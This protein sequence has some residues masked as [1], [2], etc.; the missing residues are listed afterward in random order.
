MFNSSN[1]IL[2]KVKKHLYRVPKYSF[3]T[4]V[5]VV[6]KKALKILKSYFFRC[7]DDILFSWTLYLRDIVQNKRRL[8]VKIVFILSSFFKIAIFLKIYS[9]LAVISMIS[10]NKYTLPYVKFIIDTYSSSCT[11]ELFGVIGYS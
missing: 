4:L 1:L 10:L 8:S 5:I 7:V 2:Y 3:T 11:I 9:F 6:Y